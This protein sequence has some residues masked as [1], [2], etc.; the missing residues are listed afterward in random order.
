MSTLSQFSC[1]LF[2]AFIFGIPYYDRFYDFSKERAMSS[3]HWPQQTPKN[4]IVRMPNWLGDLV[5]ATPVLAD[6]KNYWPDA[7]ITAMCQS[8]IAPL[9]LNDPNVDILYSYRRPNGWIHRSQHVEI[10]EHLRQGEYDL[11]ILL[12]NS[13]SSAW[14]FWRGH[15]QRRIGYAC[16]GRSLL[17][18]EA[19]PFPETRKTQHLVNTYKMLL[20]PL[21]IPLSNTSPMLYV[22]REELEIAHTL[23]HKSGVKD[24]QHTI[25]GINPGAAYGSAKCWL[26][27]RF[28]S[29]TQRLLEDPN[30]FVIYFGDNNG[31]SLVHEI[32]QGMP[33][34]VINLAGKTTLR[35]LVALIKICTV[36]LTNDSGPMHIAA[37]LGTPL[38]ALFGS[39]SDV[40]TGP[41]GSGK[42]IHKH[43]EC[44]PCYNRTCP[45]DFRC[46][47]RIE[48]EEVYQELL[49]LIEKSRSFSH[50]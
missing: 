30:T 19:V 15:V 16:N 4:I 11:G 44:S 39:T 37:A 21:G 5:M 14:W 9:L 13:F 8:P 38:V 31:A 42:V 50:E 46:M 33:E 29:V 45:I 20:N 25:V 17:L 40:Q 26:P 28:R 7:Q 47:K 18:S 27:D 35:E 12:T 23:L 1:L 24:G 49:K 34:R 2:F 48:V 32:C 6:L 10:I 3:S 22:D 41:Y 43:V 36:L